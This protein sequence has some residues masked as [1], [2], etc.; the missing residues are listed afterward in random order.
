M[1]TRAHTLKCMINKVPLKRYFLKSIVIFLQRG[2]DIEVKVFVNKL[3]FSNPAVKDTQ[4]QA[5]LEPRR[6][7]C[8]ML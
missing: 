5:D 1:R 4:R 3:Y 8:K 7:L 6:K 2:V